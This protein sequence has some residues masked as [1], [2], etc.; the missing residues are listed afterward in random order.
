MEA[1]D[2]A[3]LLLGLAFL[4]SLVSLFQTISHIWDS[5]Y[6]FESLP[7]GPQHARF[8]FLREA[9]GDLGAIVIVAIVL[10]TRAAPSPEPADEHALPAPH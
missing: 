5:H 7:D 2:A 6:Y 8:H 4:V 1:I 3:R 10:Q 9:M